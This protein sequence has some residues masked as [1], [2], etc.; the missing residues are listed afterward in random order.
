M[1]PP[2]RYV[3]MCYGISIALVTLEAILYIASD[4]PI[5]SGKRWLYESLSLTA[6][7]GLIAAVNTTLWVTLGLSQFGLLKALVEESNPNVN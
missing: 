6:A 7:T 4:G 1:R 2:V 3:L 5:V